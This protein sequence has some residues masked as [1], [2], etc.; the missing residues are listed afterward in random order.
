M[1]ILDNEISGGVPL[2]QPT[3]IDPALGSPTTQ[4]IN[5]NMGIGSAFKQDLSKQGLG[6]KDLEKFATIPAT[7]PNFTSAPQMI[8]RKELLD[9]Q[10]YSTYQRGI[11][12]ENVYGLNQSWYKQ[13][14]NGIAKMAA[15]AVG[16]FAQGFATIPDTISA[17]KNGSLSELSGSPDG[18]EAKIDDWVKNM[19][20]AFPNYYTRY[21]KEHPYWAMVPFATGSANFWGDKVIKNIGFTA[22]AIGSAIVQDVAIGAITEGI[23]EIPL[24]ASQLGKASLYLN[25]LFSGASKAGEFVNNIKSLGLAA[26]KEAALVGFATQK[27]GKSLIKEGMDGFKYGLSLYGSSRT[28]AAVEARDGY[29]QVKDELIN[30]YKFENFGQ[31]PT[32]QA[33]KEIDDFATDAMNVRFGINMALLTV[34]NAIQFDNLFKSFGKATE[35]GIQ[36]SLIRDIENAGQIGLKEG[37][38]DVFERKGATTFAGKVLESM[39]PKV[40][41]VLSEGVYEEGGQYAAERGTFDYYTRKY[42]DPSKGNNAKTW[43]DLNEVVSSTTKGLADQFGTSEGIENMMVGAITSLF[44]GGIMNRIDGKSGKGKDAR[45]AATINMLNNYG[46]TTT[47]KGAFDNT[48]NSAAIAAEMQDAVKNKDVYRYKNLQSE[49]L[50]GMVYSRL[51]FDMHDVTLEQLNMLKGLSKEDFEKTFGMD[52]N[53]SNKSTVNDY[54]NGLIDHANEIKKQYDFFDSTFKNPFKK[55]VNPKDDDEKLEE[56]NHDIFE[57]F[58]ED[59]V[60]YSSRP[61]AFQDRIDSIDNAI[62]KIH[63]LLDADTVSQFTEIEDLKNLA[64]DYRDEAENIE[65]G[66]DA[67]TDLNIKRE[68][69]QKAKSLRTASERINIAMSKSSIDEDEFG[70]ILN[71]ELKRID[72]AMKDVDPQTIPTLMKYSEDL[73]KIKA[74]QKGIAEKIEFLMSDRGLE[75]YAQEADV[76]S[77]KIKEQAPQ[78]QPTTPGVYIKNEKNVKEPAEVGRE[79]TLANT[80]KAVI[81]HQANSKV[82]T[83]EVPNGVTRQF[84]NKEDATNFATKHNEKLGLLSKVKVLAITPEGKLKIE[85]SKGDIY[86]IDPNELAGYSKIETKQEVLQKNANNLEKDQKEIEIKSGEIKTN[87]DTEPKVRESKKKL[88]ANLFRSTTNLSEDSAKESDKPHQ[89]R[90]RIFMNNAKFFK[91]RKNLRTIL[92]TPNREKAAGLDGT[93]GSNGIVKLSYNGNDDS[94]KNNVDTGL[95][96]AVFVEQ[97]GN[98]LYYVDEKGNRINEVGQPTDL[99]RVVFETMPT[100]ELKWRSNNEDRFRKGEE[101]A[102]KIEAENWRKI[103][104]G[105]FDPNVPANQWKIHEFTISRG[106]PDIH[107]D[108]SR[109]HVLN[110]L[111]NNDATI[112][113]SQQGLIEI[114]VTGTVTIDGESVN[115]T[116]G[117]PLIKFG[118]MFDYLNNKLFSKSEAKTIYEVLRTMLNQYT[119]DVVAKKSNVKFNRAYSTFLQNVLYWKKGS[120]TSG[121]QMF[122]DEKTMTLKLGNKSFPI[123]EI[124]KHEDEIVNYLQ[125]VYNN[126]NKTTLTEFK[127]F[128]E[129]VFKNGKLVNV[130][131]KNYQSYLLLQ[132]TPDGRVRSTNETPLTTNIKSPI[133]K[134]KYA[135]L[136]DMERPVI[137]TPTPAPKS[138]PSPTA[139]KTF[140]H[141]FKAGDVMYTVT[142]DDKI[143]LNTEDPTTLATI[144]AVAFSD[145]SMASIDNALT[146]ANQFDASLSKEQRVVNYM[147]LTISAERMKEKQKNPTPT[148]P[149][150]PQP[151]QPTFTKGSAVN[152][153]TFGVGPIKFTISDDNT[154]TIDPADPDNKQTIANALANDAVMNVIKKTLPNYDDTKREAEVLR[155]M[156][157]K[158]S[159]D[160][161]DAEKKKQQPTPPSSDIEAKKADIENRRLDELYNEFVNDPDKEYVLRK[162]EAV[163]RQHQRMLKDKDYDVLKEWDEIN[164]KYD[165]ELAA[166]EEKPTSQPIVTDAKADIE[167]TF[168]GTISGSIPLSQALPNGIYIDLGNGLFAYADKNEKIAAIVDK[169]NNYLVSKSFWNENTKKWQLPNLAN[170][171]DD[172]TKLGADEAAYIKK[173]QNAVDVL[174]ALEGKQPTS[175]TQT[176]EQKT[177]VD[178]VLTDLANNPS[179]SISDT[180]DPNE[181]AIVVQFSRNQ[182]EDERHMEMEGG[183][184]DAAEAAEV[185]SPK[186]NYFT[187]SDDFGNSKEYHEGDP[188]LKE[189]VKNILSK[190]GPLTETFED[191]PFDVT[192]EDPYQETFSESFVAEEE[193]EMPPPAGAPAEEKTEEAPKRKP[194]FKRPNG[195]EFRRMGKDAVKKMTDVEIELFRKWAAENVP[196]IPFEILDRIIDTYDGEKAWGV[197]ENG[198]A[199]FYRGAERGTEYHEIFEGIWAMFLSDEEQKAILDEFKSK[200]GTFIDRQTRKKIRFDE[201]TDLQAKERIADDF[202]EFRLGKLPARTIGEKILK[203][204]RNIL[205]FFKK[206]VSK[207]SKKQELFD[208]INVGKFKTRKA[209]RFLTTPQYS[210]IANLSEKE[211]HQFVQ[212]MTARI[213][214]KAFKLNKSLYD[215]ESI[216]TKDVFQ[217]IGKEYQEEGRLDYLGQNG[218]NDLIKRTKEF[219]RTFKIDLDEES[220]MSIN[221]ENASKN[222]YTRDTF[223]NDWKKS[224]PFPIKLIVGTL[225]KTISTNQLN[226]SILEMP[227]QQFSDEID[228]FQLLNF[229]QAFATLLN[230][231]SNTVSVNSVIGKLVNLAKANGDYARLFKRLRG[232]KEGT[233]D[234]SKFE[235]EDWRLFVNFY[236]TFTKQRPD[237]LIQY[238]KGATTYTGSA[239]IYGAKATVVRKWLENIKSGANDEYSIIGYDKVNKIYKI[240]TLE[241]YPIKAANNRSELENK[242]LF[243]N[244]MGINFTQETALKLKGKNYDDFITAVNF[245]HAYVGK[246]PEIMTVKKEVLGISGRLDKLAELYVR[247]EQPLH[248]NTRKNVEGKMANNYADSNYLSILEADFA[249]VDT[250]DQLLERRPELKDLFSADSVI[251]KKGGLFF[252]ENGDKI[253]NIKVK[254]IEGIKDEDSKKGKSVSKL[255]LGKRFILEMNQNLNGN[256]YA[257]IPADSSTE[258]MLNMGNHIDFNSVIDGGAENQFYEIMKQYLKT[259]V[260]LALDFENRKHLDNIRKE[261]LKKL[262]FFNDI[263][264]AD[265]LE[266]VNS[267]INENKSQSEIE[268]YLFSNE[269]EDEIREAIKSYIDGINENTRDLLTKKNQILFVEDN[270]YSFPELDENFERVSKL[271]KYKLTEEELNGIM[272]FA[273]MNY[274]IN[275]IEMHKMFFGD[276]FQ[277]AIKEKNGKVI[278]DETKRVKSFLSPRRITFNSQEYNSYLNR[279]YNKAGDVQLTDKDFGYHDHKAYLKTVTFSDVNSLGLPGLLGNKDYFKVNEADAASEIIDVAYREVKLKN[280]QWSNEAEAWHQWQM[281]YTR[282]ALAKKGIYTYPKENDKLK[283]HD[284][285]LLKTPEPKHTIEVLKPIVSGTKNNVSR[286]ELDLDKMSQMPMYYKAL[287]GRVGGELYIKMFNEKIDYFVMESGRKVGSEGKYS[288]YTTDGKLNQ[289]PFN[290]IVE[291]PWKSYGIQVE[292]SYEGPKEQTRGSQVTKLIS[293]NLFE[294]GVPVGDTQRSEAIQ[295]EYDRNIEFLNKL[296]DLGYDELLKRLGI[297]DL[298]TSFQIDNHAVAETLEHEM[299]RRELSEN[300]KD[301]IKLDENGQWKIPFEASNSYTQIRSILFSIVDKSILRPKM[302]GGA[303]VQ[304]PVT[305]WEKSSNGRGI[306]L[307]QGKGKDATYKKITQE[308]YNALSEEDKKNV[309]LTS[310]ELKFYTE[311]DKYC[312]ILVPC[313]FRDVL[314]KGKTDE[315]LIAFINDSPEGREILQGIGFRI[316]TQDLGSIEAVRIKGFLPDFMGSS[317][318][319]PAEITAKSGSDFDIDKLNM[320]LKSVYKDS[321]GTLRLVRYQGSEE[322]TRAFFGEVFESKIKEDWDK[323]EKALV[324]TLK[325]LDVIDAIINTNDLEEED[326]LLRKNKRV[327]KLVDQFDDLYSAAADFLQEKAENLRKGI[328]KLRAENIQAE[329][330]QKYI[331]KMYK[332]AL[333]NEYY[334]SMEQLVQLSEF[335][336]LITPLGD[337]GLKE[338]SD[339]LDELRGE[340]E[341]LIKNRILDRNYM[342]SLRHAFVVAKKWVG[343]GAVNITGHSVA[344]KTQVYVDPSKYFKQNRRD[345]K[346]LMGNGAVEADANTKPMLKHQM[347][348]VDGESY[349][350]LSSIKD[351]NGEYI[352]DKLSGFITSFVDVAKDPYILKI[353]ASENVVGTFMFLVRTGVPLRDAVMFMSQPII[354][355]HLEMLDNNNIKSVFGKKSIEATLSKFPTSELAEGFT[356]DTSMFTSNIK[357]YY[358][359]KDLGSARNMEQHLILNEFLK[360]AKMAEH[361]FKFTQATNYDTASFGSGDALFKK[362]VSTEIARGKNIISSVDKVLES[363][364]IGKIADRYGRSVSAMGEILMFEKDEYRDVINEILYQF[365]AREFMSA[366]DF[367]S[368]AS[369]LRASIIDYLLQVKGRFNSDLQRLTTNVETSVA[370]RLYE[371]KASR[372][373][374]EILKHL[375]QRSSD[376]ADGAKTITLV[377]NAK[378]AYDENLFT[379]YMRELREDPDTSDFFYDLVTVAVL[380]GSEQSA[381][382]FKNIIPVEDYSEV[383]SAILTKIAKPSDL[384][385]FMEVNAFE[386]NNWKNDEIFKEFNPMFFDGGLYQASE[387]GQDYDVHAHYSYAF[388]SV[389]TKQLQTKST[390]RRILLLNDKYNS[391][392]MDDDFLIV[393]RVVT[394][395]DGTKVDMETGLTIHPSDYAKMKEKGDPSLFDVFGYKKVKHKDGSPLE[396]TEVVKDEERTVAVFKMINLWGDGMYGAEHYNVPRKS[397]YD[398]G[399]QK[400]DEIP[401]E[402]LIEFY[403][404]GPETKKETPPTPE[405][406]DP[407]TC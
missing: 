255:T 269:N 345:F 18:A 44:T 60:F 260:A 364:F 329:F 64:K 88:T 365:A 205:E 162:K 272:A 284:E 250:L 43:N 396:F 394:L 303:K 94:N 124:D 258:W 404:K 368:I 84:N 180:D 297:T 111:L 405:E 30:Q 298:G 115:V 253:S 185:F 167:K 32:G 97:D 36:G 1:A 10:R 73:N 327:E 320:Y 349:I 95:V 351:T 377:G 372:P 101:A 79:Y 266:E 35:K 132:N 9:N 381:I 373:D 239:D 165:A 289:E 145:Q 348:T 196:M 146:A 28:E 208:A 279:D 216:S 401:D 229:S 128:N 337:G 363:T 149:P 214:E 292:N 241:N 215:V 135:I 86:D 200:S 53:E 126:V 82:W 324:E 249:E 343:I 31:A 382:S 350:S 117:V 198:I 222:E 380:Q 166:L 204:F 116:K 357:D 74:D 38:L 370:K 14:G 34:S 179:K 41:T 256:Y 339:E 85:D 59:L 159:A 231:L 379:G 142:D 93:D 282:N 319:V 285:K 386:R 158:I 391:Y 45:L 136:Q 103:R 287:E 374:L 78:I 275:N 197:F 42:K 375:E 278:L 152:T 16:T 299:L 305:L 358:S 20:D 270:T 120:D 246:N 341:S 338:L 268:E 217:E 154:V 264:P 48:Q 332:K 221:D 227:D 232:T 151:T 192:F 328:D 168:Y 267:M 308:E 367:D 304:I 89:T 321:Q 385:E 140:T 40:S 58:R 212:D 300:A 81:K 243:L 106:I 314:P 261:D 83:V 407:F 245:I 56:F 104:T 322:A 201:A 87:P 164:D 309:A 228:G 26:E 91:N 25:K 150:A 361:N 400:V 134:Q 218:W 68:Q 12:L 307:K 301:T 262:R 263:L 293:V 230:T 378:Q 194:K 55:I 62:T 223:S 306:A 393:K 102:A 71:F 344:Q 225:T 398:N 29:R 7:S 61:K 98:K 13:L 403:S 161:L 191:I 234:F 6:I 355:E 331:D 70:K 290:N 315:E 175:T 137:T 271:D 181:P 96:L 19:E 302:S 163:D 76:V 265:I 47:L 80:K 359:S 5:R 252:D 122:I 333:E 291:I 402:L 233:I 63:P 119:D 257:L 75:K 177:N 155:F 213:F 148:P 235:A 23:G 210:R 369:S 392:N 51:G 366:D 220:V 362:Q 254:V 143:T 99:N 2:N 242:I 186:G 276:P 54:V 66:L 100:T 37:S 141:K 121:N 17:L 172:A 248:E 251:L 187:V 283:N 190:K 173:Y 112:V 406:K 39:R 144:K 90:A 160:A 354:K 72:P 178:A 340:D 335:D 195:T 153:Y 224:S 389:D 27:Y 15:T 323:K 273:N 313:W 352:S 169:N 209:V 33:L 244:A 109:S 317:V 49:M 113:S 202:A 281:A 384:K 347:V 387:F 67:I 397:I 184:E 286:I 57:K 346:M 77:S 399:T 295:R 4:D 52:F 236:Q 238:S 65:K 24:V 50:F 219:L 288:V 182:K 277:F 69:A 147:T 118:D 280:G 21:E 371:L 247:A 203:F 11:D 107:T 326:S 325:D 114:S 8:S 176:Q 22:G 133:F 92:I 296:T 156:A 3:N 127:S 131:W 353:I 311:G 110:T 390:D 125:T 105:L 138:Q 395:R 334:D 237:V 318:V 174:N 336:K 259:D 342:T 310:D 139:Q 189:I 226:S 157:M 183:F 193:S 170:L 199:K 130:S 108:G 123:S 356:V 376:R 360:Y 207:P 274:V 316:P 129:F 46:I 294:N 206:F 240:S 388:P 312:E 330:K 188:K 383:T 171:K 211:A